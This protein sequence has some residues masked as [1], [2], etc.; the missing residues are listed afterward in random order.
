MTMHLIAGAVALAGIATTPFLLP[1]S[2]VVER[3][4]VLDA[5]AE[6]IFSLI[7]SNAG[8][9]RFNPHKA[10]DP[11]LRI[12]LHGPD[13]GVGSG[14]AFVGQDGR[15]TQTITAVQE[16]QSVTMLID[17]G[18]MGKPVT[19][20]RLEPADDGTRVTWSTRTDF[21]INPFGRVLALFLDGMLGADYELGLKM[22]GDAAADRA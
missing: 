13:R 1:S 20:F 9:Q 12:D 21:G 2:T 3:S 22:L 8:Y 14:F 5:S 15:G 18:P 16:N 6:K 19:T 10:K 11:D 17:L 4:A 7:A